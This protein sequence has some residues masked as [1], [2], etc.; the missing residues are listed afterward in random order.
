[1][2]AEDVTVE[3]VDRALA[4]SILQAMWHQEHGNVAYGWMRDEDSATI[5]GKRDRDWLVRAIAKARHQHSASTPSGDGET[6]K[7][8]MVDAARARGGVG[9]QFIADGHTNLW[10]DIAYDAAASLSPRPLPTREEV[11][12]Q[13]AAV[14]D[15][16]RAKAEDLA[17]RKGAT[18]ARAMA[19]LAGEEIAAQIRALLR[20]EKAS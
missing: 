8:A 3:Q 16:F 20:G 14:A 12:E 11:I 6:F 13:C 9:A 4:T 1:M 19:S 7:A 5:A 10:L 2:P 18:D 15:A 17:V